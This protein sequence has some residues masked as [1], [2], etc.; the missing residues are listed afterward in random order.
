[1][2][3]VSWSSTRAHESFSRSQAAA[4]TLSKLAKLIAQA[5][6]K[7][8]SR[9]Q[10]QPSSNSCVCT[11]C[12]KSF[13]YAIDLTNHQEVKHPLPKPHR[14][15]SC[16][17]EFSLKSS[18]QL[19]KCTQNP[20]PL[21]HGQSPHG[22]SCPVSMTRTSD[23][24]TQDKSPHRQPHLLDCSPYACAPCGRGFS[25][26]QAL[27]HHQQAGCS[28]P[29]ACQAVGDAL[30]LPADSP[31][32]SDGDS[33]R[34]DSSDTPGPSSTFEHVCPYCSRTFRHMFGLLRHKQTNHAE[35][36]MTERTKGEGSGGAM[37]RKDYTKVHKSKQ[38]LLSCR[39]C[40]MVFRSTAN[41]YVHRKEKHTR[42]TKM[43]REPRPAITKRRKRGSY[44]CQVCGKV[45]FHHLSLLAHSKHHVNFP[46]V[47][48]NS[49][50]EEN[51]P[52]KEKNSSTGDETVKASPGRP[53]K[54]AK[55]NVSGTS[56]E[57][58]A[59]ED[60]ADGEFPCP[61]CAEVFSL[62]SQLKAH[63]EL[64][65]S[66]VRRRQCSVCSEEMDAFKWPSSKKQR[67]YHCVPCQQGFSAL[68]TFLE[69]CQDHLRVRVEE[70]SVAESYSQHGGKT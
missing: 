54:V 43:H 26:K 12:G 24:D 49:F 6:P 23:S 20:S 10:K 67:P 11:E 36:Q 16:G 34:S 13:S 55:L 61:S 50:V 25:Q 56:E 29:A 15:P 19:H 59:V 5:E 41:L 32:V 62:Q 22:S 52:N 66:A 69:H 35:E 58:P 45:F 53:R 14:C 39:S 18:L 44:P 57:V 2:D 70:D 28:K 30:S 33:T 31:P 64:H 48:N 68:D 3:G 4:D 51:R 42:E 7:L 38:K 1:M 37:R 9:N 21:C 47:K 17:K 8:H 27:L 40:D 46:A 63:V 60:E 65:Q